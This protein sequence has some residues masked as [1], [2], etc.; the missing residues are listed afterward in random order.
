MNWC[1]WKIQ[2]SEKS[3]PASY[4]V[5]FQS[6]ILIL[7]S[8]YPSAAQVVTPVVPTSVTTVDSLPLRDLSAIGATS[9]IGTRFQVDLPDGTSC[10]STNGTPPS[11]NFFSGY[12]HRQDQSSTAIDL[13]NRY[14]GTGNGYAVGAVVS[15]PLSTTNSRNCDEAYALNIANK[16]LEMATFMY[17]EDLLSEQELRSLVSELKRVLFS[18][19]Q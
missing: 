18:D 12:S 10:I 9:A 6:L 7:L 4:W 8:V 15:L 3:S 14:S 2:I 13:V 11:L 5:A 17:Q 1:C 19:K 16:K